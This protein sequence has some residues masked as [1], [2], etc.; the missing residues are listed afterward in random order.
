MPQIKTLAGMASILHISEE[1]LISG[2]KAVGLLKQNGFPIKKLIDEGYFS[3]DGTVAD[4]PKLMQLI[5]MM[6]GIN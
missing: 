4:Y 2:L 6:L 3:Q 1:Q 5:K